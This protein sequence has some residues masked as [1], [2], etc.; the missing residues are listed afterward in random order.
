MRH[1]KKIILLLLMTIV[2]AG[3][4]EK[5][6]SNQQSTLTII[7]GTVKNEK[8]YPDLK[9]F[10]VNILDF[11]GKKTIIKDSIKSDGT[12][13]IKFDLYKTQD[14]DISP[15]GGKI[16][17]HPGDSIQLKIDF[18]DIGN[19]QFF[20]DCQKTNTDLNKYLNSNYCT[21]KFSNHN[22]IN[23]AICDYKSFCDSVLVIANEKRSEFVKEFNPT[24]EVL[25]WTKDYIN[26]KYQ[27][28]LLDFPRQYAYL[29]NK[30]SYQELDVPD[31][32]YSFLGNIETTFSDSIINSNIY[33]L[34]NLY[35]GYFA[36][37]KIDVTTLTKENNSSKLFDA[38]INNLENSYF[39]QILIANV[40]YQKLNQ[41][42]LDF[43]TDNKMLLE[44]NVHEPSLKIPLN[45]YYTELQ[46]E[47][48]NLEIHSNATLAKLKGTV[49]K[50]IIDSIWLQNQGKVIYIDFWATW[51]GPCKAE[52]PNSEKLKQ[53]LEGEDIVFVYVCLSSKEKQWK[54][55]LSQMQLDGQ[56]YYAD[57]K[58]SGSIY[59][60]FDFHGIPFYMLVN[61]RGYIIESG[62]YLRPSNSETINK[63]EKLLLKE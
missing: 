10:G 51:C 60:A 9:E 23:M 30:K 62:H 42:D 53:K 1:I 44:D 16:I 33:K 18:S 22:T 29:R 12:F 8:V 43:F 7:M 15:L 48:K 54:L 2:L 20:G 52:M 24:S 37:R 41:N 4:H 32:Y 61:K 58:Q 11:R 39:K 40:F 27:Q 3:C 63:I 56:H 17:V 21:F 13:K 34:L 14:I 59:N 36:Q 55:A 5:S 50:S 31:D 45:N 47:L 28:S 35:T 26:I 57:K 49:G 19:I 25:T 38:L 46:K 6:E